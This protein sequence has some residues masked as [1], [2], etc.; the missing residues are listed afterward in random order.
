M[1]GTVVLNPDAPRY[2]EIKPLFASAYHNEYFTGDADKMLENSNNY[3]ERS[4]ILNRNGAALAALLQ[5]EADDPSSPVTG[6]RYPPQ[7]DTF[8][9]YKAL[10]RR[11]TPD[12]TPGYGCLLSVDFE[13]VEST[14]AYYDNLFFY[15]GPHLGAHHSL[16]MPFNAVVYGGDEN[17][18]YHVAYGV[19]EEQIR[20]SVGLEDEEELLDT[21]KFA[22][23]KAREAKSAKAASAHGELEKEARKVITVAAEVSANFEG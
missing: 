1:G 23:Q 12:F 15:C 17:F 7:N 5:K 20:M 22:L 16:A 8:E 13:D 14:I 19:R 10:M 6:V 4:A 9:N 2:N 3:L 21:V 11:P 18:K